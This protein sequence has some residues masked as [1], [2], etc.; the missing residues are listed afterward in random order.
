MIRSKAPKSKLKK[1]TVPV[2]RSVRPAAPPMHL[3]SHSEEL[4]PR[5]ASGLW[6]VSMNSDDTLATA[7]VSFNS[8]MVFLG[9]FENKYAAAHVCK[10]TPPSLLRNAHALTPPQPPLC[11]PSQSMAQRRCCAMASRASIST[12]P[13]PTFAS[14]HS[15]RSCARKVPQLLRIYCRRP[16][17]ASSRSRRIAL[18]SSFLPPRRPHLRLTLPTF[19][20]RP[21]QTLSACGVRRCASG[22]CR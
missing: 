5:S 20:P 22:T 19:S 1:V 17:P 8:Q 21:S 12:S 7:Q 14:S 10:S 15:G 2:K 4:R 13:S 11:R 16:R 3:P 18:R 6:G 9:K